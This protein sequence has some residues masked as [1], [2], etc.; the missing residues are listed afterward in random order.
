MYIDDE[1]DTLLSSYLGRCLPEDLNAENVIDVEYEEIQFTPSVGY[2]GLL[3]DDRVRSANIAII[4][5]KLFNLVS[6]SEGMLTGEMLQI[7]LRKYHP[8]LETIVVTSWGENDFLGMTTLRKYSRSAD[9]SKTSEEYYRELLKDPVGLAIKS[10][11]V[12]RMVSER[13]NGHIVDE[14]MYEKVRNAIDGIEIF[15]EL[16]SAKIDKIVAEFES[17]KGLIDGAK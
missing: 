9:R 16:T 17:I 6:A 5:S 7:I 2:E 10:T 11:E 12:A 14:V 1:P 8:F 15:D 13:L 3:R 4:D